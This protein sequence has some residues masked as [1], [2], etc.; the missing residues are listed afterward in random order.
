MCISSLIIN[1]QMA[2][3]LLTIFRVSFEITQI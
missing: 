2:F 1:E 3:F